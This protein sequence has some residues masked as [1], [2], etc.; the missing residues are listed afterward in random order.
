MFARSTE[1]SCK[2]EEFKKQREKE[3]EGSVR[4]LSSEEQKREK[5]SQEGDEWEHEGTHPHFRQRDLLE[6]NI[7]EIVRLNP[8]IM[9]LQE[10]KVTKSA[11]LAANR[12][13]GSAKLS[14][15]W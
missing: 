2:L 10:T 15:L 11:E 8:D 1:F 4:T 9:A 6:K 5:H 13:A 12:A 3:Y 14:V 7:N